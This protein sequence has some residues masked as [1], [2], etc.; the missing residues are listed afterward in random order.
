M[1]EAEWLAC[2]YPTPLLD[3]ALG[4]RRWRKL[5]LFAVACCRRMGGLVRD[6]AYEKA[7]RAAEEFADDPA[8]RRKLTRAWNRAEA[9]VP[10]GPRR[11]WVDWAVTATVRP[12]LFLPGYVAEAAM[13]AVA[14]VP[15]KSKSTTNRLRRIEAAAQALLLRDFFGNP[16]RPVTLDPSWRT[17]TV[18]ALAEGIYEDRAFDRL[19]ILADALQDA[20]CANEEVLT[21]CHG[22]GPHARGCWVVDLILG[23]S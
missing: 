18:V 13:R 20:G 8:R 10:P 21:H 14:D 19:P 1:T 16:F 15:I 23:K 2:K 17:S 9:V 22:D 11:S 12:A 4:Q 5:R 3:F 6:A 7:L